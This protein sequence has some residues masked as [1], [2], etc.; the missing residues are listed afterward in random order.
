MLTI[1]AVRHGEVTNANHVVYGDLP[2]FDLSPVGAVQ[3]HATGNHLREYAI[4]VVLSSPLDRARHT[5]T[6]I[7]GH[8]SLDV[9]IDERLTETRMYPKWTGLRWKTV[10]QRFPLQLAAYLED[11]TTSPNHSESVF[12]VAA[13]VIRAVDDARSAGHSTIVVVGHQDPTQT[14]I[15]SLLGRPLSDLRVDPPAHG[16]ATTLATH[17]GT[18]FE[19]RHVW[20]PQN[21]EQ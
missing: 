13:R 10:E 5:A 11:A 2:G 21:V 16:S 4:D 17:D 9:T 12:D 3:A 14:L 7:A 18:A 8:H 15:L 1:I 20:T 19:K 6:A